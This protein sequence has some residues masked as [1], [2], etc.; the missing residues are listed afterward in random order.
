MPSNIVELVEL[1]RFDDVVEF[2][3][4]HLN[5]D[6]VVR[7]YRTKAFGYDCV[8]IKMASAPDIICTTESYRKAVG[9][10]PTSKK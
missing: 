10:V 8:A 3:W 4:I 6:H 1:D 9:A 7:A 5:L 2:R